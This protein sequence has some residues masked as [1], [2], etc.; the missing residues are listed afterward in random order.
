MLDGI[1]IDQA[2]AFIWASA[3]APDDRILA[4]HLNAAHRE[5]ETRCR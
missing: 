2:V 5:F 4:L 3:N 1:G